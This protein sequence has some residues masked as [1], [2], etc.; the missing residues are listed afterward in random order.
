MNYYCNIYH[1]NNI[2]ILLFSMCITIT[3]ILLFCCFI[4]LLFYY[5][6]VRYI[7]YYK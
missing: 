6:V 5:N 3:N 1:N 7:D 2:N 4:I